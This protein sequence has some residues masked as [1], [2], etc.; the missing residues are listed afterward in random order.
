MESFGTADDGVSVDTS[1][2]RC[3]GAAIPD[4]QA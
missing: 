1:V 3:K 2:E 4:R